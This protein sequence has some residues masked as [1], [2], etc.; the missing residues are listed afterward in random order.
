MKRLLLNDIRCKECDYDFS[1]IDLL[2]L[3]VKSSI[4]CKECKKKYKLSI[5]TRVINA[6]LVS[7]I[8]FSYFIF[9]FNFLELLTFSFFYSLLI[10]F[11]SPMYIKL[12]EV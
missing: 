12:I 2:S 1:Y 8:P 10:I 5:Y 4:V 6:T 3:V 7:V 11:I 9:R